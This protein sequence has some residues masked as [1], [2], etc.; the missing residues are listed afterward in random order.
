MIN[1]C[2]KLHE[3]KRH[4]S[5]ILTGILPGEGRPLHKVV[6]VNNHLNTFLLKNNMKISYKPPEIKDWL[7]ADGSYNSLLYQRDMLHLS[8][9]GYK[10]FTLYLQSISECSARSLI[11]PFKI[12]AKMT[13]PTHNS[14]AIGMFERI[15]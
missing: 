13:Y 12:P 3:R 5:I 4:A 1:I 15:F 2:L 8:V 6:S 7:N 14:S 9:E 11:P 10:I